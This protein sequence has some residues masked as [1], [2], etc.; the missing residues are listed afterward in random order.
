MENIIHAA[1]LG[2]AHYNAQKKASDL[3]S[4]L[5][6]HKTTF[7]VPSNGKGGGGDRERERE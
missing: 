1:H 5:Q 3:I 7:K 6:Y 4:E 2:L